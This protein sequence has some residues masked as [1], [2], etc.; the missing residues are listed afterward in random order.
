MK[1]SKDIKEIVKCRTCNRMYVK[2]MA[3]S[4]SSETTLAVLLASG[5]QCMPPSIA[6]YLI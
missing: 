3:R 5:G 6:S 4:I 2:Q 1:R